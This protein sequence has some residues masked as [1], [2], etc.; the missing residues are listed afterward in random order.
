V[1]TT[2]VSKLYKIILTYTWD[3]YARELYYTRL[4]RLSMEKHSSF[5]GPFENCEDNEVL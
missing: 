4:E 1:N 3:I 2:P 5:M